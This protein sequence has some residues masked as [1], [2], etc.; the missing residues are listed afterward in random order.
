[1]TESYPDSVYD[2]L[3]FE[4]SLSD[5]S[6]TGD[7]LLEG[8]SAPPRMCAMADDDPPPEVVPSEQ[9]HTPADQHERALADAQVHDED[10]RCRQQT[11][12]PVEQPTRAP[13]GSKGINPAGSACWR[14]IR[15]NHD[16]INDARM[17]LPQGFRAGQNIAAAAI[18][19][20]TLSEPEDPAQRDLHRQ[21]RNMVELAAVQQAESSSLNRRQAVASCPAGGA[22]HGGREPYEVQRAPP[23]RQPDAGG[24]PAPAAV[25]APLPPRPPIH[26]RVGPNYDARNVIRGRRQARHHADVD[27]A[28]ARAED[29]RAYAPHPEH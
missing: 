26:D 15:V 16:I 18:L 20:Q 28:A 24:A 1:M 11:P 14:A 27:R 22:S 2:L 21:V 17:Q 13:S 3:C 9:T 25:S 29:A 23:A 8:T 4:D 12:P 5:S 19:L 6:S 10:L 7:N